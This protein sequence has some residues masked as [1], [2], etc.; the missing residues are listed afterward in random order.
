MITIKVQSYMAL[1]LCL[2]AF[3]CK[4]PTKPDAEKQKVAAAEP[5]A[6]KKPEAPQFK[7]ALVGAFQPPLPESFASDDNPLT[8]EKIE[9]GRQLYFDKRLSK[10]QDLS[11]NSCHMLDKFGVDNEKTS[12]GHKGQRGT[13]NSPTV[14]NAAGH[15]VQFWDGRSPHVEHQATQPINNP[16][17]MA[18]LDEASVVAVLNSIPGYVE[19]FKKVFPKESEPVTLENAGKAMGAFER[20]LV[21]PS[22][23]DKL[24]AG[25]EAALTDEEKAGFMAFMSNGCVACHMGTLVGGTTY[26]KLGAVQP[27]PNQ[28]DQGRFEVTK[29]DQ[30]KMMF[31]APSLRN[32]EKTAP[33]FHDGSSSDLSEAVILMGKHQLGR[34]IPKEEAAKIVTW[35]KSLTGELPAAYIQEPEL[36][37]SGPSTPKP[38]PT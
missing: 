18:M 38:D 19:A 33:Y 15:F 1:G 14:Y 5:A 6:A 25:D 21:T 10:N 32:V 11:C 12:P 20:K 3:G 34:D 13:R 16:V 2:A 22:R 31:K 27:W 30:D 26:Q 7:M 36:P 4:T 24:L 35:L 8:D 9:L 29:K 17:E 37:A 28:Q 23:W